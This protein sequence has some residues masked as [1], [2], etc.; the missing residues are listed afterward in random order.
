MD[1]VPAPKYL[2]FA[3]ERP[4][5]ILSE[6]VAQTPSIE[7]SDSELA[8]V[9]D[10]GVVQFLVREGKLFHRDE[11]PHWLKRI[12]MIC[13][14]G[15]TCGIATYSKYL[16]ES[17]KPHVKAVHIFAEDSASLPE[18]AGVT[19]CWNRAGDYGRILPEI[20]KFN[21]D[22]IIIQHEFGLFHRQE[23]WNSLMSQLSRWRTV[24]VMHTVLEHDVP[25]PE[26]RRDYL[27][28]CLTEVACP[29]IIVHSPRARQT[30]RARGYAGRVHY[31]PHGCFPPEKDNTLPSTK[32]GMYPKHTIFQYGFGSRHKG[33]EIALDVVD[34]LKEKY[35]D[36]FYLGLFSISDFA[37][38]GHTHYYYE[39]LDKVKAR[40]LEKH[41]ALH[42]GF[43]TDQMI[44]QLF[45][46]SRVALYPYQAPNA[47]WASWGASGAIQIPLSL[48]MPLVLS[49]FPQFQEFEG[50]LPICR[51]TD[52]YVRTLDRIFSD[53]GYEEKLRNQAHAVS[54]LRRWDVNALRFLECLPDADYNAPMVQVLE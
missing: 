1:A 28:R 21:P 16:T 6:A 48:G 35:P 7:L 36:I 2:Y 22:L 11:V 5:Y 3:G 45:R 23:Q 25:H 43:Q 42:K 24:V 9:Q 49:G 32:Y 29:E 44:T 54:E 53:P 15:V 31:I 14:W 4:L 12:A 39:L 34:Q 38:E 26:A 40:G 47:Y 8:R 41:F 51:T 46:C 33:W 50:I 18:E 37:K 17:L 27:S 10:E 30:L 52:E 20:E 13:D 19:R